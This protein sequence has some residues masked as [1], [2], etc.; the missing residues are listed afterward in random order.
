M[1][2]CASFQVVDCGKA[3]TIHDFDTTNMICSNLT[4]IVVVP[5][6][7]W[8]LVKGKQIVSRQIMRIE[9]NPLQLNC[10]KLR[11]WMQV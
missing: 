2:A 8:I 6:S 3:N 4:L 11:E 5:L 9:D 7:F 10:G 1:R